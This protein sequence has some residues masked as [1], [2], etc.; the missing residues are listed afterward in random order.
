[1]NSSFTVACSIHLTFEK[2]ELYVTPQNKLRERPG[3][4]IQPFLHTLKSEKQINLSS[5]LFVVFHHAT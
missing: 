3:S 1:M 5:T 2:V 4:Q